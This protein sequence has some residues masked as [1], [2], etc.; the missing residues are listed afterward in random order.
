MCQGGE[1]V[2]KTD[3]VGSIPTAFVKTELV[4]E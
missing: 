4:A 2:S 1:S 3:W